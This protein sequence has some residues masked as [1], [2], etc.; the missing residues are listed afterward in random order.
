MALQTARRYG[1]PFLGGIPIDPRVVRSGD[2]GLTWSTLNID[3]YFECSGVT[4]GNGRYVAVGDA[5][6][7]LREGAVYTS[8]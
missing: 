6:Q 4:W 2:G 8:G 3:G 1:V 5:S 7:L